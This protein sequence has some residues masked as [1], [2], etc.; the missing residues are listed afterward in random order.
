MTTPESLLLKRIEH[1]LTVLSEEQ[2]AQARQVAIL[3]KARTLLHLGCST[4]EVN[5][6]LADQLG[7]ERAQRASLVRARTPRTR[8]AAAQ[9]E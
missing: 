6:M 7:R 1:E 4:I 5:A 3:R 9:H 8:H 2:H